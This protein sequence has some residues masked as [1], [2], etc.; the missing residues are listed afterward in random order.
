M[1]IDVGQQLLE[2]MGYTVFPVKSGREAVETYKKNTEDNC[3]YAFSGPF[4]F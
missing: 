2:S 3:D 4:F 1:I